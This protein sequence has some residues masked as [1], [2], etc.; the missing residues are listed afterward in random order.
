MQINKTG[1]AE[2]SDIIR[3]MELTNYSVLYIY[4]LSACGYFSKID[5]RIVKKNKPQ[6]I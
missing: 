4:F 3:P 5:Q 2:L 6:K 1:G